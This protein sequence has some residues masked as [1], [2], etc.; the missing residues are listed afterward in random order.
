MKKLIILATIFALCISGYILF[1]AY[2]LNN[3]NAM[4]AMQVKVDHLTHQLEKLK[5]M[6]PEPY[7][8]SHPKVGHRS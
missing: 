1:E 4:S 2:E 6:G 8:I 5:R 7:I 3:A